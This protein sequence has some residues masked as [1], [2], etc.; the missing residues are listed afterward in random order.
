MLKI[1]KKPVAAIL[2]AINTLRW[3]L[4]LIDKNVRKL[5]EMPET[6]TFNMVKVHGPVFNERV[7]PAKIEAA[8]KRD[9]AAEL[10]MQLLKAGAIK[11]EITPT[12]LNAVYGPGLCQ[13]TTYRATIRVV[14]DRTA[15]V[16]EAANE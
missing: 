15:E 16:Q 2:E 14:V 8:T 10:G 6:Q 12:E 5:R 7:P 13:C 4:D 9:M 3:Q 11:F 1:F